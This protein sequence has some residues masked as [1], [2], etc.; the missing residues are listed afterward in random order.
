MLGRK[1]VDN[2][3]LPQLKYVLGQKNLTLEEVLLDKSLASLGDAF[4]NFVYSFALSEKTG[5]P[6]GVK[7]QSR[8]L[9]EAIKNSGLR[10]YL[11]SRTDR[12]SQGNADHSGRGTRERS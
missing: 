2:K 7:V 9:A 4:V 6:I 10:E 1:K 11:P 8:I 12:H 3:Y 5:K